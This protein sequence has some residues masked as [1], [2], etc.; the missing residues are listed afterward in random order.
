MNVSESKFRQILREEAR[1]VLREQTTSAAPAP[2]APGASGAINQA[3]VEGWKKTANSLKNSIRQNNALN[4][5]TKNQ[6]M[7]AI[8]DLIS[9]GRGA[10][11]ASFVTAAAA[12]PGG[13]D[14]TEGKMKIGAVLAALMGKQS[15]GTGGVRTVADNGHIGFGNN[16]GDAEILKNEIVAGVG[17]NGFIIAGALAGLAGILPAPVASVPAAGTGAGVTGSKTYIIVAGDSISKIAAANYNPP[18]PLSNA[19]MPIYTEI[20]TASKIKVNSTLQIGQKLVLPATLSGGKYTL[21]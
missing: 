5:V 7:V 10:N 12:V 20:A 14:D 15:I 9:K 19:N 11:V 2:V 16:P 1:R 8:D 13:R 6:L 3:Q 18:V 17:A 21:K 4:Q